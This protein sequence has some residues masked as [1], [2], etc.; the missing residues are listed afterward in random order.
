MSAAR[1]LLFFAFGTVPFLR[2][3]TPCNQATST[4]SPPAS[5]QPFLSLLHFFLVLLICFHAAN[6]FLF[7]SLLSF[8]SLPFSPLSLFNLHPFS[9]LSSRSVRGRP[10]RLSLARWRWRRRRRRVA[11]T[12]PPPLVISLRWLSERTAITGVATPL[13]RL[14]LCLWVCLHVCMR[15]IWLWWD[16]GNIV[17]T[18]CYL[19]VGFC[20]SRHFCSVVAD[21]QSCTDLMWGNAEVCFQITVDA[22]GLYR[23]QPGL[24]V[25]FIHRFV[26]FSSSRWSYAGVLYWLLN[27]SCADLSQH[28]SQMENKMNTSAVSQFIVCILGL[29]GLWRRVLQRDLV[30]LISRC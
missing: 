18:V 14:R 26:F 19:C 12:R 7:F 27:L 13:L 1:P 23:E 29:C 3:S 15:T 9:L 22:S 10:L 20:V 11:L 24:S 17:I 8:S 30:N 6:P 21:H 16:Y 5:F 4:F 28:S 2:P 25:I